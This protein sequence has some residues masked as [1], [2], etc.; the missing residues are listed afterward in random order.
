MAPLDHTRR[1]MTAQTTKINNEGE[2]EMDLFQINVPL[3]NRIVL[4]IN[5]CAIYLSYLDSGHVPDIE[6]L[7]GILAFVQPLVPNSQTLSSLVS[8]LET[9]RENAN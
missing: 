2:A 9:I 6:L 3:M 4:A 7:D 1:V 5:M 8:L